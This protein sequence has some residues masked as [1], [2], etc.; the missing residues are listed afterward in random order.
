MITAKDINNKRFEQARPGYKP[1]EVDEFLRDIAVQ[2]GNMQK[3]KEEIERKIEV[4][5]ESVRAFKN[6]EEDLKNALIDAH[7]QGR[8]IVSEAKENANK[9]IGEAQQKAD[10]V[11]IKTRTQIDKEKQCLV[12]MQQEVTDFKSNL[13]N[14]YKTHLEQITA[15]PEYDTDDDTEEE[16]KEIIENEEAETAEQAVA[17]E[18][19]REETP[20]VNAP[21]PPQSDPFAY[22]NSG[23]TENKYKDLKFGQNK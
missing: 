11:I 23:A 13:L 8:L 17:T 16:I 10:V 20:V 22:N 14:M 15:M 2:I 12:K 18:E 7:K 4:L 5:V 3:E 1:E 19:I 6:D 21:K 9:I